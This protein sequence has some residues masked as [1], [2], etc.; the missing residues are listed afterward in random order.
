VAPLP[1]LAVCEN[2]AAPHAAPL[3]RHQRRALPWARP[4]GHAGPLTEGTLIKDSVRSLTR[5]SAGPSTSLLIVQLAATASRASA[6]TVSGQSA[7]R[8]SSFRS[9]GP[10]GQ[11]SR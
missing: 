1:N 6:V 10:R 11:V 5:F 4:G 7:R 2:K 3:A 8:V 9:D